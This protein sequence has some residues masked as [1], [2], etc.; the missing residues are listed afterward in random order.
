MCWLCVKE[1]WNVKDLSSNTKWDVCHAEQQLHPKCVEK[2]SVKLN[3]S[4]SPTCN[5][6]TAW[7]IGEKFGRTALTLGYFKVYLGSFSWLEGGYFCSLAYHFSYTVPC[8]QAL[9]DLFCTETSGNIAI[10]GVC[11]ILRTL[12]SVNGSP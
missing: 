3:A 11:S 10:C 2:N 9:P 7:V 1:S 8:I 5:I 12:T 6:I 4:R